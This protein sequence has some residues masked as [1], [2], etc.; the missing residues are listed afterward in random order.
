M[1]EEG[2]GGK[3]V[4]GHVFWV[5]DEKG[6]WH[7]IMALRGIQGERGERGDVLVPSVS[8]DGT[9]SWRVERGVDDGALP[10]PVNIKG[11]QGERGPRGQQGD[12]GPEGPQGEK[13]KDGES[14][15]ETAVAAGYT[16][17]FKD[18]MDSLSQV[19]ETQEKAEEAL[20]LARR[21]N[22]AHVFETREE[23]DAWMADPQMK[24]FLNVGDM[25]YIKATKE[26]FFWDGETEVPSITSDNVMEIIKRELASVYRPKGSVQTFANLPKNPDIGDVYNVIEDGQNWAWVDGDESNPE[27][28]WDALGPTIDLSGYATQTWADGRY[29][30]RTGTNVLDSALKFI[31][32][33]AD[34][35]NQPIF[36]FGSQFTSG[37]NTGDAIKEDRYMSEFLFNGIRFIAAPGSQP[38]F[39]LFNGGADD[40]VVRKAEMD[41]ALG[42]YLPLTGGTVTGHLVAFNQ[43]VSDTLRVRGVD[44]RATLEKKQNKLIAGDN[45][46]LTEQTDGTVKVSAKGYTLPNDVLKNGSIDYDRALSVGNDSSAYHYGTALG[47]SASAAD[48]A[49]AIG[50]GAEAAR[51]EIVLKGGSSSLKVTSDGL[52]VNG[53]AISGGMADLPANVAKF[54]QTY[55]NE[56]KIEDASG[57]YLSLL[58]ADRSML[59]PWDTLEVGLC[60]TSTSENPMLLDIPT[61]IG[62]ERYVDNAVASVGPYTLPAATTTTLGGVKVGSNLSISSDGV[63]NYSLPT[64]SASTKGGVKVD[65][66]TLW[67]DSSGVLHAY[68]SEASPLQDKYVIGRV[69]VQ[70]SNTNVFHL[71]VS[72]AANTLVDADIATKDYVD[73]LVGNIS[74]A[75]ASI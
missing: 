29:P 10:L 20:D 13:G 4:V 42:G 45:V 9:V 12:I 70:G 61:Q 19:V 59:G 58:P 21:N 28:H 31:N 33:R 30:K 44:I 47:N 41:D 67:V 56:V 63:L 36:R 1:A 18:F 11:P 8:A 35:K 57:G 48:D 34:G 2:F 25:I 66:S 26:A 50:Q 16:G 55:S 69:E 3:A 7:H 74:A 5:R 60:A 38:R 14:A 75:L 51:N 46:T 27:P 68:L 65:G 52:T 54:S 6:A 71:K 39:L 17:T 43:S 73:N 32:K 24:V 72:N 64:A 62:M 40:S 15:Y 23:H 37:F 53:E 49:T 22:H